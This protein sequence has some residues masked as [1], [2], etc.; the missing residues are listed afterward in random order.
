MNP[1]YMYLNQEILRLV[2]TPIDQ[3]RIVAVAVALA[4]SSKAILPSTSVEDATVFYINAVA[5]QMRELI[6]ECGENVVFP[7]K[8]ALDYAQQF[9][10]MRYASAHPAAMNKE[11]IWTLSSNTTAARLASFD[12]TTVWAGGSNSI[13]VELSEF[14]NKYKVEIISLACNIQPL[15]TK[16]EENGG[17]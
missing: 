12:F 2:K 3:G 9:W 7:M 6:S 14:L 1:K 10:K 5:E 11:L 8:T 15:M 16:E 17:L 4:A 13:S